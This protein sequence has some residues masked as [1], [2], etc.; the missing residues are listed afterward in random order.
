MRGTRFSEQPSDYLWVRPV[1]LSRVILIRLMDSER[2]KRT[3]NV[4]TRVGALYGVYIFYNTQSATSAP[5][6][7]VVSGIEVSH[8]GASLPPVN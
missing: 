1:R 6:L 7:H 8:G 5:R 2:T 3:E 4:L